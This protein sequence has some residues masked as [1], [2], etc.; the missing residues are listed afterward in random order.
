MTKEIKVGDAVILNA[1]RRAGWPMTVVGVDGIG[2][3]EHLTIK[4]SWLDSAGHPHRYHFPA[5]ALTRLPSDPFA[6]ES[7]IAVIE[8]QIAAAKALDCASVGVP[9]QREQPSMAKELISLPTNEQWA[10]YEL[11]TA[12]AELVKRDKRAVR[13]SSLNFPTICITT[14]AGGY[15]SMKD[16]GDALR[17][18]ADVLE[19]S[20][21]YGEEGQAW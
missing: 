11:L 13:L 19:N 10:D 8:D 14:P 12:A 4:C 17:S 1:Q 2:N 5:S 21:A 6:L 16:L 20:D 18:I 3:G 15:T 9:L 7:D